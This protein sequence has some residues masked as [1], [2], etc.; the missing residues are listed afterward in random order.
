MGQKKQLILKPVAGCP[1]TG[2]VAFSSVPYRQA[3][4]PRLAC[5]IELQLPVFR[6]EVPPPRMLCQERIL[7]AIAQQCSDICSEDS[8]FKQLCDA[9]RAVHV[10]ILKLIHFKYRHL[11]GQITIDTIFAYGLIVS[12]MPPLTLI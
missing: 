11:A 6:P 12:H 2:L 8:A 7:S 10:V 1:S 4:T 3:T 5:V 9:F